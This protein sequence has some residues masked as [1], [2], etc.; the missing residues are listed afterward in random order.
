MFVNEDEKPVFCN[1]YYKTRFKRKVL[2]LLF[3]IDTT[4]MYA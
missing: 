4:D 3:C 2:A 1:S